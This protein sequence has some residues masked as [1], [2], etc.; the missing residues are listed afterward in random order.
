MVHCKVGEEINKGKLLFKIHAND[1]QKLE[2]AKKILYSALKVEQSPC[3]PLP[4]FY[5]VIQ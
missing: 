1:D 3:E 4:L 2:Q 5:D